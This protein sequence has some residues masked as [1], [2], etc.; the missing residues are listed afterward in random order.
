MLD[1]KQ[2]HKNAA[3]WWKSQSKKL[4][5]E[6]EPCLEYDELGGY[7]P[8]CVLEYLVR[9]GD[10]LLQQDGDDSFLIIT[11]Y[12]EL[13]VNSLKQLYTALDEYGILYAGINSDLLS[14]GTVYN[15][16]F[17]MD[18]SN[19]AVVVTGAGTLD[20]F[21]GIYL[22]LLNSWG[23]DLGYDGLQYIKIAD[24]ENGSIINNMNILA[25]LYGI[26][27]ERDVISQ[28]SD[29]ILAIVF[30]ILFVITVCVLVVFIVLYLHEKRVREEKEE[31]SPTPEGNEQPEPDLLHIGAALI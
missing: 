22:E 27:A 18:E 8:V 25:D 19:H 2:L 4:R 26:H 16:H 29:M 23:V 28:Y 6:F 15:D 21:E 1:P 12:N 11:G 10:S 3:P 5:T 24:G 9:S 13:K 30:M 14:I 31:S 7:S 17:V 20:G